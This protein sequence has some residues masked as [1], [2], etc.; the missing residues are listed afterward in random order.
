MNLIRIHWGNT[1]HENRR[2]ELGDESVLPTLKN[3]ELV[4]PLRRRNSMPQ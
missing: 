4:Y 2:K 3:N 1:L